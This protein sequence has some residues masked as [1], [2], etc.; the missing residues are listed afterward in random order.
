MNLIFKSTVVLAIVAATFTNNVNMK[1]INTEK[2]TAVW[3]GKKF[4][5]Q[6]TGTINL[7]SGTLEFENDKIK[8]GSFVIDMSS[9]VVTD[10]EGEM[11]DK[12]EGHLKSDDFFSTANHPQATLD[13]TSIDNKEGY[14]TITADLSIKGITHPIT[15]DLTYNNNE[16]TTTL[17]IDRSKYNVKYGSK[18]FFKGLGDNFIYDNFEVEVS[19]IY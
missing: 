17:V 1:K 2:S 13:F 6:H 11:K 7:T 18:S 5:G 12:L 15:F 8:G 19:L 16:A 14:A 10:L 9:L 4:G 3:T